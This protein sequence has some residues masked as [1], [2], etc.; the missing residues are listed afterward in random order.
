[1]SQL[2]LNHNES[3]VQTGG[4]T[5]RTPPEKA[6]APAVENG[7]KQPETVPLYD[8]EDGKLIPTGLRVPLPK[9]PN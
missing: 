8:L 3:P 6:P 1:M 7:G 2:L 9:R 5:R 4:K